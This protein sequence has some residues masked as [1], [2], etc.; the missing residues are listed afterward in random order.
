MKKRYHQNS[1]MFVNHS[2]M[3]VPVVCIEDRHSTLDKVGTQVLFG[4]FFADT[5]MFCLAFC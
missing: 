3:V 4:D 1:D 2:F 5:G